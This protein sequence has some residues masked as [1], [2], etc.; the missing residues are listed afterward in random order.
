VQ[1]SATAPAF[2][3]FELPGKRCR[4]V[5]LARAGYIDP[6]R[7]GY[8][9]ASQ[10]QNKSRTSLCSRVSKT[11]L[12]WGS[13]RAACHLFNSMGAWQKSD[14]PALQANFRK[15]STCPT[16]N[17]V[18]LNKAGSDELE[19]CQRFRPYHVRFDH[20]QHAHGQRSRSGQRGSSLRASAK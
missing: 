19:H 5:A 8:V 16:V 15:R 13:T 17:R 2:A 20:Q 18:S 7:A 9:S 6:F 10:F 3:R 1:F 11:Q 12:A 4:A 14:V